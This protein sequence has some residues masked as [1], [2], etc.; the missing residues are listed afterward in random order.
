VTQARILDLYCGPGGAGYGYALAG[1]EVLGVDIA[2]QP[3]YPYRMIQADA[4]TLP[5]DLS[6]FDAIHASPPC[7]HYA[8][9]TRWRG[10]AEGHPDLVGPTRALL[11]A[12]GLPWV[13]ENVREAKLQDPI[14][15]CGSMFGLKV[16]RHRY[17]ET[18]WLP[19]S[20][21]PSCSHNGAL[22][23]EH[24]G[25]RAY[26]DAMGCD[27]MGAHEAREAIPPAYS[28]HIGR[29]LQAHLGREAAAVGEK[30]GS[31]P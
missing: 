28:E 13:M 26:A 7:Q 11:V 20:L 5:V 16:R 3:S 4:L 27:W 14:V 22:P 17:F 24:K 29:A 1:F 21:M 2:A 12:S 31:A 19:F 6:G 9:V 8:A 18:N 23:F 10:K 30:V 15:L 25:E